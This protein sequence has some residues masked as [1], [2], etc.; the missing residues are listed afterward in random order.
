MVLEQL[1][2]AGWA[3]GT[4]IHPAVSSRMGWTG[5]QSPC[6]LLGLKMMHHDGAVFGVPGR[7]TEQAFL[8]P[9]PVVMW[10]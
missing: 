2:Q 8:V 10:I 1:D 3:E 5:F 6:A 9:E 4:E 7:V